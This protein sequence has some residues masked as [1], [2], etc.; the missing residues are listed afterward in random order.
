M[1]TSELNDNSG[2]PPVLHV[3]GD[4]YTSILYGTAF[5]CKSDLMRAI[6]LVIKSHF[7]FGKTTRVSR[8]LNVLMFGVVKKYRDA[9]FKHVYKILF[10]TPQP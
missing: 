5:D 10:P 2:N 8:C 6:D 3:K 4:M 7:V 9:I 1:V